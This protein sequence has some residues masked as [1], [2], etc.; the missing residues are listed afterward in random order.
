MTPSPVEEVDLDLRHGIVKGYSQY[1][2]FISSPSPT[3]EDASPT[4]GTRIGA[5][6]GICAAQ[7]VVRVDLSGPFNRVRLSLDYERVR[8]W[9]L[10]LADSPSADGYG[11]VEVGDEADQRQ[12]E[13]SMA[14]TQ[15]SNLRL[16]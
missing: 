13:N 8:L 11:G 6:T 1:I 16:C 3:A 4:I 2:T 12:L 15:V 7:A 10:D 5:D 9:T 14:E